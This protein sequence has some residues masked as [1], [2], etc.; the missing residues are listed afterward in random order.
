M[1]LT[2]KSRF[3]DLNQICVSTGIT[4]KNLLAPENGDIEYILEENERDDVTILQVHI[5]VVSE[6]YNAILKRPTFFNGLFNY[7]RLASSWSLS[8]IPDII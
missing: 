3:N 8:A 5:L 6:G 7:F 1:R 4:C 2:R